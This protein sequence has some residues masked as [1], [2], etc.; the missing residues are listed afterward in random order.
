MRT[1]FRL[2]TPA[3]KSRFVSLMS[4]ADVMRFVGDGPLTPEAAEALWKKLIDDFYPKGDDT[5]WAV[6]SLQD[7]SYIG[8]ASIRPRPSYPD[9]WEIGYILERSEWGKGLATEI[10]MALVDYG[11][12]KLGFEEVFATVDDDHEASISVLKK[13]GL[14]FLRHD[15]DDDGRYSV[16]VARRSL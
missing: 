10:A 15:F 5:I 13:A 1:V 8:H 3:D 9:E 16:Y 2:Y 14:R 6:F 7:E 4:D 12:S 11:F